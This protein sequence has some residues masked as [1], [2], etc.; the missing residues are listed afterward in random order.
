MY[1]L[2]IAYLL[3]WLL[4]PGMS[5]TAFQWKLIPLLW[6]YEPIISFKNIFI[7]VPENH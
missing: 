7:A 1:N 2:Y 6:V 5:E 3:L 4:R